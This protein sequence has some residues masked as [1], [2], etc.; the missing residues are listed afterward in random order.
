MSRIGS[1]QSRNN[2]GASAG[3]FKTMQMPALHR[4]KCCTLTSCKWRQLCVQPTDQYHS[5]S[6][7]FTHSCPLSLRLQYCGSSA[8]PII[9]DTPP[10]QAQAQAQTDSLRRRVRCSSG[11]SHSSIASCYEIHV[12]CT[13]R[14]SRRDPLIICC[15]RLPV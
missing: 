8:A 9:N 10:P 7:S 1:V 12:D 5:S 15:P 4:Y 2:R 13:A 3:N 11:G 6:I 14:N